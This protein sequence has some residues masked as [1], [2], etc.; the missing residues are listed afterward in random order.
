M[1]ARQRKLPS[2]QDYRIARDEVAVELPVRELGR[3]VDGYASS[4]Q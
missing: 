4:L 1:T 2:S 3:R